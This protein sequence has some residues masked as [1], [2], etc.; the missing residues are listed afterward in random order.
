MEGSD[1]SGF[2]ITRA[3]PE[4]VFSVLRLLNRVS[5]AATRVNARVH[6]H[7]K[8]GCACTRRSLLELTDRRQ[9]IE[10]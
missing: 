3:A 10:R 2:E 9:R 8:G 6:P 1:S 5:F 7:E 4:Q